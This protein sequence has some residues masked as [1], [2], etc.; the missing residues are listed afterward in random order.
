MSLKIIISKEYLLSL[1]LMIDF[2]V[3]IFDNHFF[4]L[5]HK[6]KKQTKKEE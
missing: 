3:Q 2:R 6:Q 4:R 1:F 5:S